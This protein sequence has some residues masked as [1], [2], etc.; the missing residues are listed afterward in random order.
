MPLSNRDFDVLQTASLEL[1]EERDL[2]TFKAAAPEILLAAIPADYFIWIESGFAGIEDPMRDADV[3]Q[4]PQRAKPHMIKRILALAA[5]HPFTIHA[6]K[7]GEWGPLRLSDFWSDQHL[8]ST[9]HWRDIFHPLGMGRMLSDAAFRDDRVGTI[10]LSRPLSARDFSERDRHMLRL[11]T[12]HFVQSLRAAERL[13]AR[14]EG[15]DTAQQSLGLTVREH[16]VATWLAR[17]RTNPEI[18]GILSMR[19]RTVEKHV[20][21]ILIKLGVENRTAAAMMVSSISAP[22]TSKPAP[23]RRRRTRSQR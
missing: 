3:W 18:A 10:N 17:G 9:Q 20:E 8:K 13:T 11:L 14:R 16:E 12:P 6:R 15:D 1:H 7:T 21:R 22:E 19:P 2:T 5:D 23:A 4:M